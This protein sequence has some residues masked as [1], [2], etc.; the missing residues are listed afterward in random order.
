[1][2]NGEHGHWYWEV[3]KDQREVIARGIT[4]TEPVAC[5]QAHEA[6]QKAGLAE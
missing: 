3:I 2:P 6:A 1:M 4:D 5:Q